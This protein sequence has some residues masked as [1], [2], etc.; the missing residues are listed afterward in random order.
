MNVNFTIKLGE[1][2]NK[3]FL[4]YMSTELAKKLNINGYYGEAYNGGKYFG[5]L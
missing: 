2:S 3:N 4:V 5:A 1:G